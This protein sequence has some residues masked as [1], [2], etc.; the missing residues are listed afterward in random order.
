MIKS[1]KFSD[2]KVQQIRAILLSQ[3]Q[4]GSPRDFEI[5]VNDMPVVGRTSSLERFNDFQNAVNAETESVTF[6]LFHGASNNNDKYILKFR[7]ESLSGVNVEQMVDRRL[8]EERKKWRYDQIETENSELKERCKKLEEQNA[9]LSDAVLEASKN[10]FTIDNMGRLGGV[11]LSELVKRNPQVAEYV[12]GLAGVMPVN[13]TEQKNPE[14]NT[15]VDKRS[16]PQLSEEERAALEF[17]Q[18]LMQKFTKEERDFITAVLIA[19][20]EDKSKLE[21]IRTAFLQKV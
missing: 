15:T 18:F 5:Q 14:G 19:A 6:I 11:V 21:I 20:A 1:E 13:G 12:K 3:S 2:G 10:K 9:E 17:Y 8:E 16:G 7:D 4:S